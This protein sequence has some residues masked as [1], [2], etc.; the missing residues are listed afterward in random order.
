[1]FTPKLLLKNEEGPRS[2]SVEEH[3]WNKIKIEYNEICYYYSKSKQ[4]LFRFD[5]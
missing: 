3:F 5:K 2:V 1:M 4:M